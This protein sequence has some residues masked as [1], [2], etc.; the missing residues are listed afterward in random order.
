MMDDLFLFLGIIILSVNS[1]LYLIKL[2]VRK[3]DRKMNEN[4]F[5]VKMPNYITIIGIICSLFFSFL[6]VASATFLHNE[7][8]GL[9][10]YL[11]FA[12]FALLGVLLV[13]TALRKKIMIEE[14]TMTIVPL[15][16]KAK[17]YHINEVQKYK[18]GKVYIGGKCVFTLDETYTGRIYFN[19]RMKGSK[20]TP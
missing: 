12:F 10:V 14:Q 2:N 11:I 1:V 9:Y 16:K 17:V 19:Q 15:F 4:H 6:L 3:L 5:V 18:N 13:Y 20:K 8:S 7:S